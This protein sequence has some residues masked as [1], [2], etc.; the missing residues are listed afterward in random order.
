MFSQQADLAPLP[1][2]LKEAQRQEEQQQQQRAGTPFMDVDGS[3]ASVVAATAALTQPVKPVDVPEVL[4]E[5]ALDHWQ[6][7]DRVIMQVLKRY[8]P[9][10]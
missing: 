10:D 7:T 2:V 5:D 6:Q 8:D 9:S 1:K 4:T 3:A